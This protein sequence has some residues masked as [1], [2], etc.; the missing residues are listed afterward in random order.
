MSG[1]KQFDVEAA[2]DRAMVVFWQR[3]YAEASLDL[4]GAA[5]G[6]GRGSLYGTFGGKAALFR[7]CLDR[8]SAVYSSQFELALAAHPGQPV[9]AVQAFFGVVLDRIADPAV[10][11]GCL[12]AQSAAQVP[13]LDGD[14]RSQVQTLLGTQRARVREALAGPQVDTE[15][16]DDLASYVVA[17]NQ[18]LAVM[19]RA[20]SSDAELR[21]IARIATATVASALEDR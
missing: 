2:L 7:S 11:D 18:A 10:P 19:S 12:I 3:G 9:K 4:L 17:V 13:L 8:Y 1:R 16:I 15:Q 14:S 6:L 21:S 20:G 5:T